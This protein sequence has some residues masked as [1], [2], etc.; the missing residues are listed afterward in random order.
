MEILRDVIRPATAEN[1]ED[2]FDSLN[3]DKE[4]KEVGYAFDEFDDYYQQRV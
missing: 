3:R 4:K 2:G 1:D